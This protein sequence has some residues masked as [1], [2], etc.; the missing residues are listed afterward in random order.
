MKEFKKENRF[1][2]IKIKD[3]GCLSSEQEIQLSNILCAI[4]L[5]RRSKGKN[6]LT[7]VVVE[8]DW[9]EYNDVWGIIEAR[10]KP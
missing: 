2:V 8:D 1:I 4:D 3:M 10:T 6:T 5:S 9:P 7:C